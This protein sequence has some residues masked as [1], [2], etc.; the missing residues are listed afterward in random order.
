LEIGVRPL[1]SAL[2]LLVG[3]GLVAGVLT[4]AGAEPRAVLELFTSQGCS[5]CPAADKLLG[6]LAKDPSVVAMSLNID[7]WD[8]LGWKDTLAL[9]GH[10]SRQRAYARS[11][12]DRQVYTPQ[13]VVNGSVHVLGHDKGA[14]ERAIE[15]TRQKA[16]TL[17]VPVTLA[18]SGGKLT[19]DVAGAGAPRSKSEVWLCALTRAVPVVVGRGENRGKTITYHNVARRWTKLGEWSGEARRW[20]FAIKDLNVDGADA[21]AVM[22]QDGSS[23]KPGAVLGAASAALH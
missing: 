13:M 18:T 16:G 21:A 3:T 8:Y 20:D 2:S 7:Y 23:D 4:T 15:L 12:G 1:C 6:E 5:S 9:P 10:S 22:V 11:R 14:I 19:V 17:A